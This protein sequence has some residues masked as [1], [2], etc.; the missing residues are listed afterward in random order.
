MKKYAIEKELFEIFKVG[1]IR[2]YISMYKD[3]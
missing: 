3:V 2:Q 1:D